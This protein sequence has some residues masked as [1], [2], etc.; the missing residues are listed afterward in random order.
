[1]EIYNR[2]GEKIFQTEAS[3]AWNT[4]GFQDGIYLWQMKVKFENNTIERRYG[5]VRVLR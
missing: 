3:E 1:M 2:W 5:T 4:N